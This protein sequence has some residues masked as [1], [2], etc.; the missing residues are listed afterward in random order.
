MLLPRWE[1]KYHLFLFSLAR[2]Y[3]DRKHNCS[4]TKFLGTRVLRIDH[5]SD[6]A[7][8]SRVHSRDE[9]KRRCGINM[10]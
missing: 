5:R 3:G 8:Y 1:C 4:G 10:G 6:E 9:G 7:I 2:T